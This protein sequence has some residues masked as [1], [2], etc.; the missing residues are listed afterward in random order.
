MS[1][2]RISRWLAR[3]VDSLQFSDPV[4]CVYNPLIYARKPH[5]AYL[6]RHA[7]QGLDALF[8]GMNPGPWGMAQTGVPFGEVSLV[9]DFLGIHETVKQPPVVHPKRPIEGFACT[10]SEVSGRRL[11]SWVQN[12]FKK[13]STFNKQFFIANYCP[14]VFMEG[15]GRNRTPDKLFPH[16]RE[17][18]FLAC[19]EALRRL[20]EWCQPKCVIGV[21]K[22]AEGRALAALGKTDRA[23]GTIL[24]PSPA[25]PAAN[26]G[27]Q[28]QA[29]KQLQRQGI[30]LPFLRGQGNG[31]MKGTGL[32]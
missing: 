29:E 15:S 7:K 17:P 11:W 14:L 27:W 10:R 21:G 16:E 2:I 32:G 24:H 30:K 20:V 1:P 5:E 4:T 3:E 28:E 26:R 13:A 8:L 23:I 25:S 18:L 22:F 12:R 31:N 9:R 19:D 6:E